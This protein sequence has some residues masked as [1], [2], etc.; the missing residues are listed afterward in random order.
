MGEQE[1]AGKAHGRGK[2]DESPQPFWKASGS[3]V[4]VGMARMLPAASASIAPIRFREGR[5]DRP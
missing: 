2:G 5:D 1:G 3:I 4:S